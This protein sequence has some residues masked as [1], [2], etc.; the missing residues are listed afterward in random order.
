MRVPIVDYI[1]AVH[2]WLNQFTKYCY[3]KSVQV[4]PALWGW[5]Y[6]G[7]SQIQPTSLIQRQLN[8]VGWEVMRRELTRWRPDLVVATF[9]TPA[10]VVSSLKLRGHIHVP[11]A[12]VITDHAVHSQWI[13]PAT[14]LYCVGSE[15]VRRGLLERGVPEARIRVTGIPIRQ[16]FSIP[17]DVRKLR[18]KYGVTEGVPVVLV[19][20]GAY[21]VMSDVEDICRE[22][23]HYPHPVQVMVV[24]GRNERLRQQLRPQAL[25]ARH[26][27]RVFGFVEMIH[28]LM[29][30]ADL[31]ITKAGGLTISEAIAMEL[32]MLIYR[33]IPGQEEANAAYLTQTGVAVHAKS[34][35]EVSALLR[36]LLVERPERRARMRDQMRALRRPRAADDIAEQL[37]SL[38][39][40][41]SVRANYEYHH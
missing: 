23:F 21:G 18:H 2:P 25:H 5:F 30:I 32:P 31:M 12:T 29:A 38:V 17:Q 6:R 33:P 10:G 11:L 37:C 26:P 4:A 22:L 19:M 41:A 13:H 3:L 14:D 40:P 35:R 28:E 7:T 39:N 9:P 8:S 27:V 1:R 24:C 16:V 20:G 15:E 36:D 34:R